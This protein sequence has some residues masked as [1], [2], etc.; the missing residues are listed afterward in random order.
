MGRSNS[1]SNAKKNTVSDKLILICISITFPAEVVDR[2]KKRNYTNSQG[3]NLF[4]P[5]TFPSP[6]CSRIT[7]YKRSLSSA[8]RERS[9]KREGKVRPLHAVASTRNVPL[10]FCTLAVD[11]VLTHPRLRL[12][13][14]K[15]GIS[16]N[17]I[18]SSRAKPR[19]FSSDVEEPRHDPEGKHMSS[20]CFRQSLRRDSRGNA[21]EAKGIRLAYAQ[22]PLGASNR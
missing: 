21:L 3:R 22:A 8:A 16:S 12:L 19:M 9:F 4:T 10:A 17:K 20:R 11:H 15:R 13:S 2:K 5:H 18:M 6:H 7:L 14:E 1:L